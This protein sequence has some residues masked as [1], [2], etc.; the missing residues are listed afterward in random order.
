M[1]EIKEIL[2]LELPNIIKEINEIRLPALEKSWGRSFK[3][4]F[5]NE[6]QVT[7]EIAKNYSRPVNNCFYRHIKNYLPSFLEHTTDGSD[8]IFHGIPI[9]DKNSFSSSGSWVGNGFKKTDIHLLKKFQ[10]DEHGKISHAF[11]AFVDLDKCSSLW[12]NKNINT[13]RSILE[14]GIQD[15]DAI[16]IVFGSIKLNRKKIKP[17]LFP[18][19]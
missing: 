5:S 6:N 14:F 4:E 1:K 18:L 17:V 3:E 13:N 7:V 10:C 15:A 11:I 16:D 9:E 19:N 12:S 2:I 8:Y